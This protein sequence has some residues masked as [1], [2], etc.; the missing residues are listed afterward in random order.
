MR[1]CRWVGEGADRGVA[2]VLRQGSP[3]RIGP[4]VT[5]L[6]ALLT[7]GHHLPVTRA[8]ALLEAMA[9]IGMST[10]FTAGVRGHAAALLETVFLPR[11]RALLR[12]SPVLHADET[13]GRAAGALSYMHVA[14]T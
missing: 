13:T 5:A 1:R 14:C 4:Y 9:G 11:M 3:V 12:T 6:A 10:G 2:L 7:C 8:T